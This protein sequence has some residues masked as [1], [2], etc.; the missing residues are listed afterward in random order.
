MT[1]K[2]ASLGGGRPRPAAWIQASSLISPGGWDVENDD[3]GSCSEG[4]AKRSRTPGHDEFVTDAREILLKAVQGIPASTDGDVR[5]LERKLVLRRGYYTEDF[6]FTEAIECSG[7]EGAWREIGESLP[8]RELLYMYGMGGHPGGAWAD[9]ICAHDLDP[10]LRVYTWETDI[11]DVGQQGTFLIATSVNANEA[12][13]TLVTEATLSTS[14]PR[15]LSLAFG[16]LGGALDEMRTVLSRERMVQSLVGA[17]E[18]DIGVSDVLL[19]GI[20]LEDLKEGSREHLQPSNAEWKVWLVE[21]CF[22][23]FL[24]EIPD[25]SDGFTAYTTP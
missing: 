1:A 16:A 6:D 24:S 14:D 25:K 18:Q 17:L 10:C 19:E 9:V 21:T 23:H 3:W 11:A 4:K 2:D 13:D 7:V 8:V 12:V 15:G 22:G 5:W 20:N